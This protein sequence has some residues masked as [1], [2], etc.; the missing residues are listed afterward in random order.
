MR[1][2]AESNGLL[3]FGFA[4]ATFI[5]GWFVPQPKCCGGRRKTDG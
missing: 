1:F 4:L 2:L 5:I 3:D